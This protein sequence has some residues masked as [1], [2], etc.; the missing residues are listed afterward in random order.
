MTTP[1][2]NDLTPRQREVL[3][4]IAEGKTSWETSRILHCTEATV[5][6]HRSHIYRALGVAKA[7]SAALF[8]DHQNTQT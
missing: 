2:L 3:H 4:W 5:K 1:S 6:K 8:Y 7:I